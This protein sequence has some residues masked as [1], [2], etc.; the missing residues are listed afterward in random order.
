MNKEGEYMKQTLQELIPEYGEMAINLKLKSAI[1]DDLTNEN[2][3]LIQRIQEL[4]EENLHLKEAEKTL[5][6]FIHDQQGE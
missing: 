2:Q 3:R 6:Q 4:E 1:I 5:Q